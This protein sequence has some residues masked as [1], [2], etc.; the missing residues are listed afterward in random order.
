LVKIAISTG[1]TN[2][3][4]NLPPREEQRKKKRVD[5]LGKSLATPFYLDR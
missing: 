3:Y 4:E 2:M 5:F 1:A